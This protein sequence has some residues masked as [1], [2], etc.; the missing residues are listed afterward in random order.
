MDVKNLLESEWLGV[1]FVKDSPTKK[2]TILSPGVET[3]SKDG[4]YKLVELV[5]VIDGKQ[6][7]WKCNKTSLKNL[8]NSWGTSTEA[9]IGKTVGFSVQLLQGGR[10]GVIGVPQ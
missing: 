8:S 6:K 4:L 10:E 3:T 7:K 9:W 1:Q 5:I 2:A